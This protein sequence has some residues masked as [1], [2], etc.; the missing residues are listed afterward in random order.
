MITQI[1]PFQKML[2]SSSTLP[3]YCSTDFHTLRNNACTAQKE[4]GFISHNGKY[5]S[6]EFQHAF[7]YYQ[8]VFFWKQTLVL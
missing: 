1:R 4:D 5:I 3:A 2:Y 6:A 7:F 8:K